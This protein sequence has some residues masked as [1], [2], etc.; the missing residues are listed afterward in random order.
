MNDLTPHLDTLPPCNRGQVCSNG[1][2]NVTVYDSNGNRVAQ[3]TC[4]GT[5]HQGSE[6]KLEAADHVSTDYLSRVGRLVVS[7]RSHHPP[8]EL[9]PALLQAL[10]P[11]Q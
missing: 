3:S 7:D 1:H 6:I 10:T 4:R 5:F 9:I 8:T 2:C 11:P